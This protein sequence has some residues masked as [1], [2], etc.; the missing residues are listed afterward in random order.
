MCLFQHKSKTE[1]LCIGSSLQ[2]DSHPVIC[3]M[4]W[5][6]VVGCFLSLSA[7]GYT[8]ERDKAGLL[9]PLCFFSGL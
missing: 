7:Q 9:C 5:S 6:A 8:E 2:A 4:E 3:G 1:A